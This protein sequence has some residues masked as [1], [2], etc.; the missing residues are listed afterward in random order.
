MLDGRCF[1][2]LCQLSKLKISIAGLWKRNL[3]QSYSILGIHYL[4][5]DTLSPFRREFFQI[6][7]SGM[8]LLALSQKH[9]LTGKTSQIRSQISQI[10]RRIRRIIIQD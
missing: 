8:T 9:V 1:D 7:L 5:S 2:V 3:V 6:L 10:L 4:K